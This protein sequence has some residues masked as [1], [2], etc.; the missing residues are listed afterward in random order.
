MRSYPPRSYA[1]RVRSAHKEEPTQGARSGRSRFQALCAWMRP[2]SGMHRAEYARA[3][4]CLR[5]HIPGGAPV[6][7]CGTRPESPGPSKESKC[8][9]VVPGA[10]PALLRAG[11]TWS[12]DRRRAEEG[13]RTLSV[14]G[15]DLGG[16]QGRRAIP[17]A[18]DLRSH[19]Q[20]KLGP[21]LRL[22]SRPACGDATVQP[23]NSVSTTGLTR[24][25]AVRS[26]E[27]P[28]FRAT[29]RTARTRNTAWRRFS[30]VFQPRI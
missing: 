23:A 3:C 12:R 15:S 7:R 19:P 25:S 17:C 5:G 14:R 24:V 21:L 6:L 10:A 13:P 8:H 29:T 16:D 30:S 28:L 27:G 9:W 1:R 2:Q 26:P 11:G 18:S 20:I 4:A 22:D